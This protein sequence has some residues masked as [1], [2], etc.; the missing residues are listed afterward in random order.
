MAKALFR[1][2]HRHCHFDHGYSHLPRFVAFTLFLL[3]TL[4]PSAIALVCRDLLVRGLCEI[5]GF[6]G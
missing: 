1:L 6:G 4:S 2:R 5:L 3:S